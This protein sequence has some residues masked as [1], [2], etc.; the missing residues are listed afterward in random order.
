MDINTSISRSAA[1]DTTHLNVEFPFK[2]R[3]GNFINGAFVEPKSGQYF[4]NVTP[5]TGE[6]ICECA[7]SN[8]DDIEAALD[9]AHAALPDLGQDLADRAFQHAAQDRGSDGSQHPDAGRGR[10]HRQWQADPRIPS[11]ADVALAIDHFRYFAGCIRAEEGHI[12]EIDHNT[13]AYHIPEPLG[14]VGQIIPWNFPL[15]MAVLEDGSGACCRQLRGAQACRADSGFYH[16]LSGSGS[17]IC[18]RPACSTSSMASVWKQANRSPRPT[19][20]PRSPLRA[21][22]PRVV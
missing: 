12:S 5:I 8:A 16:G 9:A 4:E 21:R 7:R 15:L 13:Y 11:R 20:L 14:V 22:R 10:N 6:V 18:C 19:A 2:P 17:V 3:Y 1:L